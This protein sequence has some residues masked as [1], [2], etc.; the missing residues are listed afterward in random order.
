M[1]YLRV[2]AESVNQV[3]WGDDDVQKQQSHEDEQLPAED[4]VGLVHS[5]T[6]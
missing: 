5:S 2:Q 6:E 3:V 4:G 1:F